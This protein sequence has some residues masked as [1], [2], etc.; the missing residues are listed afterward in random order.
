MK[1]R[2][3]L[4]IKGRPVITIRP[5]ETVAAAIQELA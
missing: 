3:L 2:D 1:I 4:K 5:T